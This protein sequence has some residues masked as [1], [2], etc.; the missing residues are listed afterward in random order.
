MLEI[1]IDE[2]LKPTFAI[3][4]KVYKVE[5]QGLYFICFKC[6]HIG[7]HWKGELQRGRTEQHGDGAS[8]KGSTTRT[9][10]AY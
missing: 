7:H 5:Y 1:K 6:G 9:T 10:V 3:Q 2:P 8:C 4:G